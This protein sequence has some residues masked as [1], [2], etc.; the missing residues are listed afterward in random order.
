MKHAIIGIAFF[1]SGCEL[2]KNIELPEA[3]SVLSSSAA[4]AGTAVVWA[5][6]VPIALSAA[7]AG[8]ATAAMSEPKEAQLSAE[9]ITNIQN[10]WQAFAVAFQ[11]LISHAFEIVIAIGVATIALPMLL[12]YLLGR[13][14]QR[15]EDAKAISGLVEKIGKMKDEETR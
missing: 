9:Q 8:I 10:P 6:P 7:S 15:P 2:V 5:H 13:F 1:I 11:G 14:K 12:S 3:T 4:A